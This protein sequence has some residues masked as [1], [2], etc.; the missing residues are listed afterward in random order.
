MTNT[1]QLTE[2][3][4]RRLA[5]NIKQ[6]QEAPPPQPMLALPAPEQV[7]PP[8]KVSKL[9]PDCFYD[10]NDGV[11]DVEGE[12]AEVYTPEECGMPWRHHTISEDGEDVPP[13]PAAEIKE[14]VE[15]QA[16]KQAEIAELLKKKCGD[17]NKPKFHLDWG[18]QPHQHYHEDKDRE[19]EDGDILQLK[20]A[21]VEPSSIPEWAT[22]TVTVAFPNAIMAKAFFKTMETLTEEAHI[23]VSQEGLSFRSMDPSHVALAEIAISKEDMEKFDLDREFDF[24][25]RLDKILSDIK[26]VKAKNSVRF[27]TITESGLDKLWFKAEGGSEFST[28]ILDYTPA[29]VPLPKMSFNSKIVMTHGSLLEIFQK[30][31]DHVQITATKDSVVFYSRTDAGEAKETRDRNDSRLLEIDYKTSEPSVATYSVDYLTKFMAATKDLGKDA[32]T[33]LEFSTK[34]PIR[35]TVK[36]VVGNP[37]YFTYYLAPRIAE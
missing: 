10:Y 4:R 3:L 32:T 20:M 2:Y 6:Q 23:H 9:C 5:S 21:F 34:L 18:G 28:Q 15:E 1:S 31:M 35:I 37:S 30:M 26:K 12:V 19:H 16:K 7:A 14:A 29:D 33:T 22:P 36:P 24:V 25:I 8:K 13:V 17:C 27:S 11:L